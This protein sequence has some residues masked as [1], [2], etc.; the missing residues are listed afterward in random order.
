[1]ATGTLVQLDAFRPHT[2]INKKI[3]H[4]CSAYFAELHSMQQKHRTC[5]ECLEKQSPFSVVGL[6]ASAQEI[7]GTSAPLLKILKEANRTSEYEAVIAAERSLSVIIT[8]CSGMQF[9]RQDE[10]RTRLALYLED[11]FVLTKL[12]H[13]RMQT[14]T[15]GRQKLLTAPT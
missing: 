6:R 10:N 9:L 3:E 8:L 11:I 4:Y 15:N 13:Q 14:L 7:K 1:M 5:V 2:E 12:V